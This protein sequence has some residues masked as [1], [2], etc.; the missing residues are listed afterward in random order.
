M[1]PG[2]KDVKKTETERHESTVKAWWGKRGLGV[3]TISNGLV[4]RFLNSG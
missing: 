1:P 4:V 2:V 3:K